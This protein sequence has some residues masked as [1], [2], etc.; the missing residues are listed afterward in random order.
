MPNL[1][2][3]SYLST[4]FVSQ[5]PGWLRNMLDSNPQQKTQHIMTL[6]MY[7]LWQASSVCQGPSLAE[8][9]TASGR[10]GIFTTQQAV[11]APKSRFISPLLASS[12][13]T[14]SIM[15]TLGGSCAWAQAADEFRHV[16]PERRNRGKLHVVNPR[17]NHHPSLKSLLVIGWYK[18]VQTIPKW[19][20]YGLW[21]WVAHIS[22]RTAGSQHVTT[23]R[24]GT[25]F[26]VQKSDFS[27]FCFHG[28]LGAFR[29]SLGLQAGA[30]E[31]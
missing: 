10:T 2:L 12:A 4:K 5:G 15:T 8:L 17:I 21:C 1:Y 23:P 28:V 27:A 22:Q 16:S 13:E 11:L 25:D 30:T 31:L 18:H 26:I 19:L 7:F 29:E 6:D 9:V 3:Q 24:L 14:A 20:V